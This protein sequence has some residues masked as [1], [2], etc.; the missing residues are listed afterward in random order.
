MPKS[1]LYPIDKLDPDNNWHKPEG[2]GFCT[3]LVPIAGIY[4]PG[5]YVQKV[6]NLMVGATP[7]DGAIVGAHFHWKI[8]LF[9]VSG[10]AD[11][12]YKIYGIPYG[13]GS[14]TCTDVTPASGWSEGGGNEAITTAWGVQFCTFG[15]NVYATNGISNMIVEDFPFDTFSV[16]GKQFAAITPAGSGANPVGKT[17]ESHKGHL[18]AGNIY[19]AS[20]W[21]SIGSGTHES[22]VWWSAFD[23][24]ETF[25][26]FLD[27]PQYKGT[28]YKYLYDTSGPIVKILSAG[29]IIY[30]FKENSIYVGEGPPFTFTLFSKEVGCPYPNST[31]FLDHVV[32]F[33]SNHGP[34]AILPDGTLKFLGDGKVMK[35]LIGTSSTFG[36]GS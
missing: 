17:I 3:N 14:G 15:N 33:M 6:A 23:Q 31:L 27:T 32:Y 35:T 2:M 11:S 10:G 29:D 28:G 13:S 12:G 9:A 22:L 7:V 24:A 25:G 16:G 34:T 36:S 20:G 1:F 21:N 8:L 19:M 18:I 30:V 26:S 4:H 5:P